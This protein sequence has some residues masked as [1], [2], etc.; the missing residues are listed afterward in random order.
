MVTLGE[1]CYASHQPSDASTST[2]HIS[3]HQICFIRK[4]GAN[5]QLYIKYNTRSA[6]QC[7]AV[8]RVRRPST[9]PTVEL[10]SKG[11][12]SRCHLCS[13][14]QHHLSVPRYWL[15]TFGCRA[16]SGNL[17]RTVS[18]TRLSAAAAAASGNYLR[19]TS[20]TVNQHTQCNRDVVITMVARWP[21]WQ[22]RLKF[23]TVFYVIL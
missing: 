9:W 15:S 11:I 21:T 13:A 10:Q 22:S 18:E 14:S 5:L 20:S 6:S 19:R 3:Y 17:Y 7:T 16:F 8:C 12:A 2:Y 4:A 23:V 1:G